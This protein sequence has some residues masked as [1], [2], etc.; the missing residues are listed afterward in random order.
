MD[1]ESS[2]FVT[3]DLSPIAREAILFLLLTLWISN[4]HFIFLPTGIPHCPRGDT[5]VDW[6]LPPFCFICP[7]LFVEFIPLH[8]VY[9]Q[10]V[11][12][13]RL[14]ALPSEESYKPTTF[15]CGHSLDAVRCIS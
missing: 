11:A 5:V 15:C 8:I 10:D 1:F 6:M 13:F 14:M 3:H 7:Q 4:T 9:G 2:I 12:A